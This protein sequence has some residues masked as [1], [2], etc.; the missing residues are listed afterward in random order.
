[1]PLFWRCLF[2]VS[3]SATHQKRTIQSK[4][5][6]DTKECPLLITTEVRNLWQQHRGSFPCRFYLIQTEYLTT[7]RPEKEPGLGAVGSPM[8]CGAV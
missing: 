5:A 1:M 6:A 4:Q 2:F 7:Q 8:Y 3:A